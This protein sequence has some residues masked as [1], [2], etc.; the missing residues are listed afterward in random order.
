MST[1]EYMGTS[2]RTRVGQATFL[3]RWPVPIVAFG[4]AFLGVLIVTLLQGVKPFYYDSGTYWTLGDTFVKDGHFSLLNFHSAL[5]GYL[6]PLI[7]HGL[8]G[9]AMTVKW[10]DSTSAKLFNTLML[11]LIGAVL[12][13]RLAELAWRERRWSVQRRLALTALLIV[14][15][16]GYLNY[17]LSDIPA[18]AMVLLAVVAVSRSYAPGW[19]LLA[20]VATAAAIDMR[21]SFVPLVPVVLALAVWS[22]R[23][24]RAGEAGEARTHTFRRRALCLGLLLVGF[25]TISLPQSLSAHRYFHTWSFTPGSAAHLESLQL[26]NGLV[27]ELYGTYIGPGHEPA[28][29]YIDNAGL[30]L[31]KEQPRE[32]VITGAKQYLGLM[33]DH[34]LFFGGVFARHVI[35]GLDQRYSTPYFEHLATDWW[36]RIS[37]FALIFLGLVR[38]L[39]PAARRSLGSA[40]WRY[41]VVLLVCCLTALPS[42]ME[43]RYLLPMY[44][45]SYILVL[46]PGWPSPIAVEAS[47]LR[48]YWLVGAILLASLV[49]TVVVLHVTSATSSHVEFR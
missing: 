48:R 20:G 10:R 32:N 4:I 45:L 9:L 29:G 21:P 33:V 26:E 28:M 30:R 44:L 40:R 46:A 8:H 27:L 49:F 7:D 38:V 17:P 5:R 42:A 39:W 23:E 47:G 35:N 43:T 22:W 14:F 16:S 11:S 24:S 31:L 12:A 3:S 18:L 1:H 25:V 2:T 37:G 13:P 19:M 36:L 6:L 41:P 34:P 15:W